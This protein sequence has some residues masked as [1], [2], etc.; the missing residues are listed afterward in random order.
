MAIAQLTQSVLVGLI[1]RSIDPL[2]STDDQ[3]N[4]IITV[5]SRYYY[6][7]LYLL[8]MYICFMCYSDASMYVLYI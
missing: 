7:T 8:Y 2:L 5:N 4:F 1:N 3:I 6:N